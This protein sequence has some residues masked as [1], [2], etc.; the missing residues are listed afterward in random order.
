MTRRRAIA[1]AGVSV[2]LLAIVLAQQKILTL[3]FVFA[4]AGG[5]L[6]GIAAAFTAVRQRRDTFAAAGVALTLWIVPVFGV[7]FLWVLS[8]WEHLPD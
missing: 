6:L 7:L 2:S 3:S 4:L 5:I 8:A 1:L